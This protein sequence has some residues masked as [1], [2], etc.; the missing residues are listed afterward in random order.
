MFASLMHILDPGIEFDENQLNEICSYDVVLLQR[1][2]DPAG[3]NFSV[4]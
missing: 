2:N 3:K 4:K 1:V